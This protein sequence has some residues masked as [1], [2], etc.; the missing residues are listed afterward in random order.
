VRPR[1]ISLFA[2]FF[3]TQAAMSALHNVVSPESTRAQLDVTFH[4]GAWSDA[5]FALILGIR[6]AIVAMLAWFVW[7]RA[8]KVA[9]WIAIVFAVGRLAQLRDA[10][11]GL[12]HANPNSI[13][14]T[15]ELL[16]GLLAVACLFTPESR[17]W[18]RTKGRP[19][20]SYASIFE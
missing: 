19:A 6:I 14:W 4:S 8:S 17:E 5:V 7:S 15:V 16:V 13:A 9:K 10:W 12:Q 11:T 20:E 1:S 2:T 18:F 3:V